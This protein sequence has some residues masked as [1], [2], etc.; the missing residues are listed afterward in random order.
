MN[1]ERLSNLALFALDHVHRRV[2][3]LNP[4]RAYTQA[5]GR[6]MLGIP[7]QALSTRRFFPGIANEGTFISALQET[8]HGTMFIA[9]KAGL[10]KFDVVLE[11]APHIAAFS[12]C[13]VS[14]LKNGARS[15]RFGAD[16]GMDFPSSFRAR[17]TMSWVEEVQI[18]DVFHPHIMNHPVTSLSD[19]STRYSAVV[20][21]L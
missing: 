16:V 12:W 3:A 20:T 4:F 11:V 18:G 5:R 2:D 15:E 17:A 19:I 8:E 1:N 21:A 6:G 13:L 10:V 14:V 7:S 9:K